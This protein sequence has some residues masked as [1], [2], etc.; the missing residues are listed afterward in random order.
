[1]KLVGQAGVNAFL[2]GLDN[3]EVPDQG[4]CS[5]VGVVTL[6]QSTIDSCNYYG[7]YPSSYQTST[8]AL[9]TSI[10]ADYNL[11]VGLPVFNQV[12]NYLPAALYNHKTS[13]SPD[14]TGSFLAIGLTRTPDVRIT[15]ISL[16]AYYHPRLYASDYTV[17]GT[18]RLVV[19]QLGLA[20]GS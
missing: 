13:G 18:S 10:L 11:T 12:G 15:A 5:D 3:H 1:M 7:I 20:G 4:L 14:I 6:T 16:L 8:R 2:Q 9:S 19:L 17:E